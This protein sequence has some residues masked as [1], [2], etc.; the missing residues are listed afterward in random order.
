[1]WRV[2]LWLMMSICCK[3]YRLASYSCRKWRFHEKPITSHGS[4]RFLSRMDSILDIRLPYIPNHIQIRGGILYIYRV[5]HMNMIDFKELYCVTKA[6][7]DMNSI[8]LQ[9][10]RGSFIFKKFLSHVQ[11]SRYFLMNSTRRTRR[12]EEI[13]ISLVVFSKTTRHLW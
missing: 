6:L 11:D 2:V 5:F 9:K 12:R 1:M 4:F 13:M 3:R 8:L 10:Q 7:S